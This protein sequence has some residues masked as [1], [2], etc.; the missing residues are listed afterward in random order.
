MKQ[1]SILQRK[2]MLLALALAGAVGVA[3]AAFAQ[4]PSTSPGS[5]SSATPPSGATSPGMAKAMKSDSA[6][7]AWQKLGSKGYVA[8]D[9]VKDLQGFSF[10][11]ADANSDGRL[12]QDE[13][14]KAWSTY[15]GS[16]AAPK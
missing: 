16:P 7:A 1:S 10:D 12:S 13:F 15:A 3:G 11:T 9:D 14:R 5:P 8:K 4:Q 2:P 6:D